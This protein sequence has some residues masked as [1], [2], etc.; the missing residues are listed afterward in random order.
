MAKKNDAERG[1]TKAELQQA[2]RLFLICEY[3]NKVVDERE[4]DRTKQDDGVAQHCKGIVSK[5]RDAFW[6]LVG[7]GIWAATIHDLNTEH[8]ASWTQLPRDKR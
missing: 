8:P 5:A 1:M 6:L 2:Q 7:R 4:P 3:A